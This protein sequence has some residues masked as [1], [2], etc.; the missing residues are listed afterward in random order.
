MLLTCPA[1]VTKEVRLV[2]PIIPFLMFFFLKQYFNAIAPQLLHVLHV[3]NARLGEKTSEYSSRAVALC[4]T[5]TP[6]AT[7]RLLF[8]PVVNVLSK[9]Q[10]SLSIPF[11]DERKD[12]TTGCSEKQVSECISNIAL[13]YRL[14]P[15]PTIAV[16]QERKWNFFSFFL[17]FADIF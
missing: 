4:L 12:T 9:L 16:V 1:N 8:E 15:T 17:L 11:E 6:P 7:R 3:A 13:L 14:A 5:L 10:S 2:H